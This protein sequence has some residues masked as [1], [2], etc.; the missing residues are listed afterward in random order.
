[1]MS[2][3]ITENAVLLKVGNNMIE[4]IDKTTEQNGT[5]LSRKNLMAIQGFIA[6]NTVFNADGSIT[7]TND[8][9]ETLVTAFDEEGNI[10][11]TFIG[12]KEITKK[13]IFNKDG[14][15]SEVIY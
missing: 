2:R 7:E 8:N 13:T 6:K 15:V 12:E 3:A 9:G 4:F 11:E 14:S 1:M 5:P 10:T